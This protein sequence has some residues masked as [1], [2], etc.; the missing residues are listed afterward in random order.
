MFYWQ[1][2]F[3]S[4]SIIGQIPI[5]AMNFHAHSNCSGERFSNKILA[6]RGATVWEMKV[7][8]GQHTT[9]A[10]SIRREGS[11]TVDNSGRQRQVGCKLES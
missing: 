6:H 9:F 11:H 7:W 5:M 2:S 4:A 8:F 3:L 10:Q 1:L